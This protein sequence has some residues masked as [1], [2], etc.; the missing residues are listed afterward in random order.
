MPSIGLEPSINKDN[1][2]AVFMHG[3]EL[4]APCLWLETVSNTDGYSI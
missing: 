3:G 1:D 2:I 4:M